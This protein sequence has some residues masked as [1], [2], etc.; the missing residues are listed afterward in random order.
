MSIISSLWLVILAALATY[1]AIRLVVSAARAL[2]ALLERRIV[3]R[4]AK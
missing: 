1:G 4:D 2:G 3:R